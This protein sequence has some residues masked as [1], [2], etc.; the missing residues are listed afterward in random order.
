MSRRLLTDT[1]VRAIGLLA[2]LFLHA[3]PAQTAEVD[4]AWATNTSA[5]S[6]VFAKRGNRIIVTRDADLYGSGFVIDGTH[7][8]G[9]ILSCAIK[10][11]KEDGTLLHIIALCSNDVALQT[12]QFTVKLDE[13]NKIT[14]TFPGLPELDTPYYRCRL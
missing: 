12:Y 1:V 5:C 9:K 14:R 2:F 3:G 8:R 4:G 10:S 13:Q 11:R 6:K 7:L